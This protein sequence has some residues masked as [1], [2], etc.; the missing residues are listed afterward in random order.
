M[1]KLL[2][3][4][5]S[6]K[7]SLTSKEICMIWQEKLK[8][9]SSQFSCH[10]IPFADGGEG[11][12][13]SYLWYGG[14]LKKISIQ[15]DLLGEM[16][17]PYVVDNGTML[18]E[19]ASVVGLPLYQDYLAP[20]TLNTF[21]LGKIIKFGIESGYRKFII[22]LGGSATVDGGIG[23]AE[24]LGYR[25]FDKDGNQVTPLPSNMEKIEIID[26]SEAD[27][28]LSECSF[29]LGVDV[30][31]P[32]IGKNGCA[33]VFGPQKKATYEQC[34]Q[35]DKGLYHLSD[36][37]ER[38]TH[39]SLKKIKGLGAAGGL[40][41]FLVALNHA[42]ILNGTTLLMERLHLESEIKDSDLIITGEGRFDEQS[43]HG[44]LIS[45]LISEAK[46]YKVPIWV[47]TGSTT[48]KNTHYVDRIILLNEQEI[49]LEKK[50]KSAKIDY[51][52]KVDE[53]F[54]V[55]A[56]CQSSEWRKNESE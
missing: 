39:Q 11:S 24:A 50:M 35:L 20:L 8:K 23:L 26:V 4:S 38:M 6:F 46:K 1:K 21:N 18:I 17:I 2:V 52:K 14:T 13:E 19:S 3:V 16:K 47:I 31:N 55:L 43:L 30:T 34:I 25:F 32:L 12:L 27:K 15:D 40:G 36:V 22:F 37:L 10:C 48:F 28:R 9:Y 45:N 7:G 44:K 33:F 5:D 54:Q 41:L 49:P 51:S 56:N 53:I 29:T 42:K